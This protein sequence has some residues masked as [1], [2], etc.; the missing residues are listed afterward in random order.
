MKDLCTSFYTFRCP[1]LSLAVADGAQ[2]VKIFCLSTLLDEEILSLHLYGSRRP[3]P[4][5][6][7]ISCLLLDGDILS[8][9]LY[10]SRLLPP[11]RACVTR[12]FHS[13]YSAKENIPPEAAS[14]LAWSGFWV[15]LRLSF[16]Q[17]W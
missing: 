16:R 4:A 5:R 15:M 12:A 2:K 3:S 1:R 17:D 11:V 13:A 14:D 9:Y 10:G 6:Y 8:L 7:W